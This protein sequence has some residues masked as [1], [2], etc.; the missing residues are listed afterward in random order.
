[1]C[2]TYSPYKIQGDYFSL[3]ASTQIKISTSNLRLLRA[4]TYFVSKNIDF[5]EI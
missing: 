2:R 5:F 1:M 4:I 3:C